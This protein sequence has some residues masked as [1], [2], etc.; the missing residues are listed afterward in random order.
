MSISIPIIFTPIKYNDDLYVD[1][2]LFNNFPINY[3]NHKNTLGIAINIDSKQNINNIMDYLKSNYRL[4]FK[5]NNNKN[6][7]NKNNVIII[8]GNCNDINQLIKKGIDKAKEFSI[9]K[10]I[11]IVNNLLNEIIE[12][13]TNHLN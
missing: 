6:N 4:Y 7:F 1:G 8:E 5:S 9:N 12:N 11:F 10:P 2:G 3:C 13:V